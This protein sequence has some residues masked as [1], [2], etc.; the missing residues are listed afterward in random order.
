VVDLRPAGP[1][2]AYLLELPAA[3]AERAAAA[4]PGARLVPKRPSLRARYAAAAG[5]REEAP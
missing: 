2:A 5:V 1:P 4:F 3:E